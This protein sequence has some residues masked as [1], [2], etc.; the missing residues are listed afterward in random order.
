MIKRNRIKTAS[1]KFRSTKRSNWLELP[2]RTLLL[3]S[4]RTCALLN[5]SAGKGDSS[6]RKLLSKIISRTFKKCERPAGKHEINYFCYFLLAFK[7]KREL[8]VKVSQTNS[9]NLHAMN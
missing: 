6:E 4:D 8:F 9:I 3:F 1:L 5:T 2:V 7:I